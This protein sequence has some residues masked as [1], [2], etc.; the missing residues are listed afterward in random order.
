MLTLPG[1]LVV[2]ATG[3]PGAPVSFSATANDLVD[4][5]RRVTCVPASGSTFAIGAT[6]VACSASDTHGN[7]AVGSFV[8]YVESAAE[9]LL[10]L[11]SAV[12]GVGP[13]NSLTAKVNSAIQSVQGGHGAGACTA[14]NAFVQGVRAQTGK[15]LTVP[16]ANQFIADAS[17]IEAVLKC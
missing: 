9:Q 7:I 16:Q 6:T 4:G 10:D 12:A 11:K 8:V 13:G 3:P 5:P 1:N 2:N 15:K 14:L 17:R